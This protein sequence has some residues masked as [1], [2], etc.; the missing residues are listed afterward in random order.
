MKR[1]HPS[2]RSARGRD[3]PTGLR[4]KAHIFLGSKGDYYEVPEDG[5]I[6]RE[7]FTR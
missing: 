4:P 1:A 7:E 5:L 6:R 3:A 2:C